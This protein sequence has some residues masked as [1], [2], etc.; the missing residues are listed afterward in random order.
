MKKM[1]VLTR[2]LTAMG[3]LCCVLAYQASPAAAAKEG[4]KY[5]GEYRV[6]LSNEPMTLDPA[7]YNDVYSHSVAQNVFDGL[8]QFDK[9]LSVV[10]CIARRWKISR[11]HLTYVFFLKEGVRFHNGREVTADDFIYSFTRILNPEKKSPVA[12]LFSKIRGG[13]AFRKGAVL[14]VEG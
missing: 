13:D 4:G 9:N 10:P 8:V 1:N 11:D 6:P 12:S 2:V 5:G 3:L 14:S 7:Y